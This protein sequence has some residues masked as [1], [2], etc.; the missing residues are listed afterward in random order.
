MQIQLGLTTL[1]FA[2]LVALAFTAHIYLPIAAD[3]IEAA[4]ESSRMCAAENDL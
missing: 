2:V 4:N 1:K 3:P